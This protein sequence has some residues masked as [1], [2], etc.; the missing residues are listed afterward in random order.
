MDAV[1]YQLSFDKEQLALLCAN[2]DKCINDLGSKNAKLRKELAN[3]P[4]CEA[5]EAMLDCDECL[6]SDGSHKE[7]RRLSAENAKLRK[8]ARWMYQVMDESCA[9]HY[10]YE[11]APVSM[12]ALIR[13]EKE[14][15]AL[16]IEVA[17]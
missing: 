13:A 1:A 16:G 10:P 6:R 9:T 4:K 8:L 15:E 5:C 11:P 7:R 14:L 12:Q 3:A 17:E 2:Y